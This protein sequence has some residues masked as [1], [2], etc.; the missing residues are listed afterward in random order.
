MNPSS[1]KLIRNQANAAFDGL[2]NEHERD[3]RAVRL[4]WVSIPE[5]S[6]L[7]CRA[8]GLIKS[9]LRNLVIHEEHMAENLGRR[10][11]PASPDAL[12]REKTDSPGIQKTNQLLYDL[13]M[14]A[15]AANRPLQEMLEEYP[16]IT[17]QLSAH[18]L[19]EL[20]EPAKHIGL[21][22]KITEQTIISAEEWLAHH[23]PGN[24]SEHICPLADKNG[25]CTISIADGLIT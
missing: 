2:I 18:E 22:P 4:E 6:I 9:I 1:S 23:L 16:E 3:Y 7:L 5:S 21:A 20:L 15:Y 10:T 19:A 14:R 13:V 12:M 11:Y 8:M 25:E 17:S 24:L